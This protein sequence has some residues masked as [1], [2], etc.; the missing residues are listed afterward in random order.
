MLSEIIKKLL[1]L[2]K[3]HN[4]WE[5]TEL[6]DPY[7]TAQI[8]VLCELLASTGVLVHVESASFGSRFGSTIHCTRVLKS[9]KDFRNWDR[10]IFTSISFGLDNC[11]CVTESVNDLVNSL[12]ELK[13]VAMDETGFVCY[14]KERG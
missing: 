4:A 2:L 1:E 7:N 5:C 3:K 6:S 8:D 13:A 12:E 14:L 11:T 10:T 9:S